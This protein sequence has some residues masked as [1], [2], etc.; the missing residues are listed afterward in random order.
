[1]AGSSTRRIGAIRPTASS[2][3]TTRRRSAPTSSPWS[4][5]PA[6][7][8][9][10]IAMPSTVYGP[11]DH[12]AVGEQLL[13]AFKGTLRYRRPRRRRERRSSTS[14]TRPTGSSGCSID[15]RLGEAYIA[16]RP[17]P[18]DSARRRRSPPA[19][20]AAGRRGSPSR[21]ACSGSWCPIAPR[22]GGRFGVPPTS[23]RCIRAVG[24]RHLL[25]HEREGRAGARIPP[26][27]PR[28]RLRDWLLGGAPLGSAGGHRPACHGDGTVAPG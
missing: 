3:G 20:A 26:A 4:G 19:S 21:R 23:A 5:S 6:A 16:G 18:S 11:G 12:S 15:G 7:P 10:S 27:R 22:L 17:R 24:R 2:A 8:R 28:D 13:A 25:G 14:T 9:S 1:M